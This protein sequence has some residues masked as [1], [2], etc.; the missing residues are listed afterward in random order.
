MAGK[1]KKTHW[2][3]RRKNKQARRE[4]DDDQKNQDSHFNRRTSRPDVIHPGSY[5]SKRENSKNPVVDATSLPPKRRYGI[6]VAFCGKNYSGMQMNEGVKTIEA[7]LERALF[8]AGGISENNYGFLQKIGWSRAARTDK[9]VHAAGQLIAVKLHVGN[10]IAAFVARVNAA[11]PEDIRVMQMVTVPKNFNAKM[12]CDQRIYEYL[13]PTFIFGERSFTASNGAAKNILAERT[14]QWASDSEAIFDDTVTIDKKTLEAQKAFRL[15][16]EMLQRLREILQQYVGTHNFHNF[17]SKMEPTNPQANRYIISFE[18]EN[19]FVQNDMEWVRLRVVGQSFLLHHIRKMIGT[20]VEIMSCVA[21]SST[22]ER[23][24]QPTKMDLP[25]A[26]GVGLYLAQACFEVHNLKMTELIETSHPPLDLK[27]P[28]VAAAVEQFKRG[29]IFDYIIKHEESTRTYA[30]WLRIMELLPFS[31]VPKPYL[32]WKKEKEDEALRTDR[33]GKRELAKASLLC[34]DASASKSA[35]TLAVEG[36]LALTCK[37]LGMQDPSELTDTALKLSQV[38]EREAKRRSGHYSSKLF[39]V[40]TRFSSFSRQKTDIPLKAQQMQRSYRSRRSMSVTPAPEL[41]TISAVSNS[42]NPQVVDL[43]VPK[44]AVTRRISKVIPQLKPDDNDEPVGCMN[45]IWVFFEDPQSST[46]AYYFSLCIYGFIILSTFVFIAETE[47]VFDS[48]LVVLTALEA[49]CAGVFSFELIARFLV[50]PNKLIFIQNFSNWVDF[51]AVFPYYLESL[52]AVDNAG[53]LGAIRIVRLTRVARVLKMSRYSSAIQVFTQAVAISFKPLTMLI[54][55]M[56]IAMIIFSSAIYFAEYTADGCRAE[57][58]MGNCEVN[59]SGE[60]STTDIV[61]SVSAAAAVA[62]VSASHGCVCVDPNPYQGI[63]TSFWWCIVTMSTVGYGDM[64]PVTLLGKIV[65][66]C[67]VLTG[68]LVLALPITVI[69]TNFQK[70]MKSFMH[71]T[72]MSNVDY[73]KG[74]RMICR[75][76]IEAILGRFHAVTEGIHLDIDDIINVYDKDNSGMLEDDELAKFRN[77]LEVLQNRAFTNQLVVPGI[78]LRSPS[79]SPSRRTASFTDFLSQSKATRLNSIG[80]RRNMST[81]TVQQ[82]S[83]AVMGSCPDIRSINPTP[84]IISASLLGPNDDTAGLTGIKN[85]STF[86]SSSHHGMLDNELLL[87]LLDMQDMFQERL[88]ETEQRLEAKMNN[89]TKVLMRLEGMMEI[90][91]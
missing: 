10:D 69:G 84:A 26:P 39:H 47:A 44:K 36:L 8:E 79:I 70:V 46:P 42:C 45:K 73:L 20:A 40:Q 16:S 13:A 86:S 90:D 18:A 6:W 63:A 48:Y 89:I 11:L 74:K 38:I 15:S 91:R 30:K 52:L 76:E 66:C 22:I 9:G 57:G 50:C 78:G 61:Y 17:T 58:W 1:R 60:L 65:G 88:V 32:I 85:I 43:S 68:M 81:S 87:R 19:P 7:E 75:N 54:F 29:F 37:F 31:Y 14:T 24:L 35:T 53:S 80:R 2:A 41:A 77:D 59:S 71:E 5:A 21:D 83:A 62:S 55:L 28:A 64:T 49:L 3:V 51:V 23:A 33:A 72:M 67:T 27:E 56:S 82:S 34:I 4:K 25:K 12:S